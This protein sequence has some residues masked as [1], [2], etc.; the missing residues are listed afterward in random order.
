MSGHVVSKHGLNIKMSVP[1]VL[2]KTM[3]E[4]NR[5]R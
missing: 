3:A 4:Q 5:G 1:D 2:A